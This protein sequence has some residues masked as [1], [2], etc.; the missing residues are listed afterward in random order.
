MQI[1]V[2]TKKDTV[3]DIQLAV[4][5]LKTILNKQYGVDLGDSSP[6]IVP[7]TF[8]LETALAKLKSM[9]EADTV[10]PPA[11]VASAAAAS[12]DAQVVEPTV[13][14]PDTGVHFTANNTLDPSQPA[15]LPTPPTLVVTD[16][17]H[18]TPTRLPAAPSLAV[19]EDTDSAGQK[20]DAT[21]HSET[22]SKIA[23]GTWR[24]RR[25]AKGV[26]PSLPVVTNIQVA[27]PTPPAAVPTPPTTVVRLHGDLAVVPTPPTT[28]SPQSPSADGGAVAV[29]SA[30]VQQV[31][32]VIPAPPAAAFV[33]VTTFKELMVAVAQLM[34]AKKI[35]SKDVADVCATHGIVSFQDCYTN[36]ALIPS[37]HTAVN[38]IA[39]KVGV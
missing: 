26:V 29:N 28:V 36:T 7:S 2:D 31:A 15:G 19:D 25:N 4:H 13:S 33:P 9:N 11:P 8:D 30:P 35:T 17:A 27:V 39:V 37:V 3:N 1:I 34:A 38:A 5:F 21:I 20:W 16:E 6:V 12:T 22:R 18:H 10:V 32:S 23:D 24:K 14:L